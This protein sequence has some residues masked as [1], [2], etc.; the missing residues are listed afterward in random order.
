M[1]EEIK[2]C[3]VNELFGKHF[4]IP[5]YQRGYRW[6]IRQITDLLKDI[7]EFQ[8]KANSRMVGIG[9][10]Y[11]LQPLIVL[12]RE[13]E[14]KWEVVDGQQRLT[15]MFILLSYLSIRGDYGIPS[16][17]FS[18]EYE[19][20][21]KEECSS[22]E[23]L[24]N[25][26]STVEINKTNIDFYRMSN[27]YLIIKNWFEEMKPTIGKIV[28]TIISYEPDENGKDEANNI[29]F[30][31]YPINTNII[32]K[33]N[34][35][36]AKY[37]QGKIDLTNAELIKAIFYLTDGE[38]DKKKHQIKIGY[39]WDDIENKLREP[40]FWHF[41]NPSKTYFNH[42][43]FI[44]DLVATKYKSFLDVDIQEKIKKDDRLRVYYIFNELITENI[45]IYENSKFGNTRDF[46]WDE[47]KTY[48][49]T[50]LE[51]YHSKDDDSK[52]T[53]FHLIGFLLQI[54]GVENSIEKIKEIAE[55]NSKPE[56]I[57]KLK[58]KI[59]NY[60]GEI[61]FN[62][63]GYEDNKDKAKNILL[64][65]NVITTMNGGFHK[66]SFDRISNWSLEHIHAQQSEEI[67]N[68]K[69]KKQLLQEQQEDTF[70]SKHTNILEV[71]NELLSQSIIEQSQFASLQQK[72][73]DLSSDVGTTIHSIKNLALLT[74]SDN[75]S[76]NNAP[77]HRKRD[78]IKELDE[79]GSFIPICTNNVFLKYYSKNVEQNVKWD[80][81][82]M[83]AYLKEM[84]II[85][86]D[87]LNISINESR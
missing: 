17:L 62:E 58:G 39:E 57:Q 42:I 9:E 40:D 51:W 6:E 35:T 3:S 67:S 53:Y 65:F 79:K 7:F 2:L 52:F 84:K 76:L 21:E 82:D 28:D 78:K 32:E 27:A 26:T 22:K 63:I 81:K 5:A 11:C 18:I 14:D 83:D 68:E 23:F 66:F 69:D 80:K 47:I 19:T 4:F 86:N 38:K 61:D 56:F 31:W 43:E 49:R 13:N 70:I 16:N 46:L 24:K 33:P 50:F 8:K 77:F 75:S 41:I 48:F 25:I 30:I 74:P 73:F 34:V 20:R 12:Y 87:Y 36:F 15:T 1:K 64:L 72:I 44:F 29:R 37:N 45:Q 55:S 59:K 60:F 71:I 54:G 10:F 85:L